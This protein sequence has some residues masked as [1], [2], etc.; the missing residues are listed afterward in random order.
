MKYFL[1]AL[2]TLGSLSF[3]NAEDGYPEANIEEYKAPTSA[4]ND[5]DR[6]SIISITAVG[7]GVA[8]TFATSHAQ[9]YALAK[10]AATADAYRV[11]AERVKGVRIDGKDTIKNMAVKSSYVNTKVDAMIRNAKVV[12]TTFKD[13]MCEV[14]MEITIDKNSFK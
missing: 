12:E 10:R 11:I 6:S 1:V 3:I 7:Q 8:P 9:A 5:I 13:G 2:L 14:E 4:Y